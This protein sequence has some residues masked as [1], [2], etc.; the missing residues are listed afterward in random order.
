MSYLPHIGYKSNQL[1]QENENNGIFPCVGNELKQE[2]SK[3]RG[4]VLK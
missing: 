4:I 2:Q 1:M 3:R